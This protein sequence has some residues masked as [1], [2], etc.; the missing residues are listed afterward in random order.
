MLD[1]NPVTI[2][3]AKTPRNRKGKTRI[4]EKNSESKSGGFAVRAKIGVRVV[5]SLCASIGGAALS[6]SSEAVDPFVRRKIFHFRRFH[7]R[8]PHH[9]R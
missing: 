4:S 6:S 9:R 2:V 3:N 1:T 7:T 8:R 5:R